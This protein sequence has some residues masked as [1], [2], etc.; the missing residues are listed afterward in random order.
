[1]DRIE[2]LLAGPFAALPDL[3]R[4]Q[5]EVRPHHPAL[6]QGETRLSYG[7]LDRRMDLIA[8]ALQ[9]DGVEPGRTVGICAATSLDHV[10]V[11]LGAL[12]AGAGVALLPPAASAESLC[13]MIRDSGARLLFLDDAGAASLQPT[14]AL[15]GI[16]QIGLEAASFEAWLG[17]E[18]ARPQPVEITP[19]MVFNII[20]SS[21]TTGLPKGIVQSHAMRFLYVNQAPLLG[22]GPDAVNLT[23]TP[24]CSNTTL[25]TFLPSIALGA[26]TVLMA[27]FETRAYLELAERHR[28]T[29]AML[30]PVQYRR[31]LADPDFDSF[32][33]SAFRLKFCT[34]APFP[35]ALKAEVLAR[36]PGGLIEYYGMTE[37]GGSCV[38][39]A[40]MH[41]DR[42][43]TVG[44]PIPGHDV[45]IIDEDGREVGPGSVGEI[46][47]HSS[48]IMTEY[49]NRPEETAATFW[50]APDGRRFVR[51]GDIGRMDEDG[52]LELL[53]RRKDLIISGGFNVYPSDLEAVLL[54]HPDVVDAAVVGVPSERW[55]ETPVGFVIAS[56]CDGEAIRL[57]ANAQ[58]G[59]T[60]RLADLQVMADLPRN[61]IGKV[62]KRELRAA[63]VA[64]ESAAG[65]AQ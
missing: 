25:T 53:D 39:F 55:G 32:D 46:V 64:G 16:L 65:R 8:A 22:F 60:Q 54:R 45:R 38:L 42:L 35:A 30:V 49:H 31:L 15:P 50:T 10:C 9:R 29:H 57:W 6:I 37:G 40:H 11:L 56:G 23:S 52:F 5:A 33:L 51:T 1:M 3:I 4:L 19:E 2:A 62:L 24:L 27:K 21:G 28:V 14:A 12:R 41:P 43:H 34:S 58:L 63:Y 18:G 26:T 13:A 36:W 7:A 47:G 44:Q 59:K 61:A 48:A 17:H 20:Y